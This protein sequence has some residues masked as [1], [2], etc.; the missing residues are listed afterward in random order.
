MLMDIGFLLGTIFGNIL[1]HKRDPYVHF[2][3]S[4]PTASTDKILQ[5]CPQDAA[6]YPQKVPPS[7]VFLQKRLESCF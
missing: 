4:L 7:T 1:N 3:G 5:E 2:Q 6:I